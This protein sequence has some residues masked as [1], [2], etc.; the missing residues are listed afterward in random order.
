MKE[1]LLHGKFALRE[2]E[3]EGERGKS[4]VR[5]ERRKV[6]GREEEKGRGRVGQGGE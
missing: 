2:R 1:S 4:G 5:G 3:G 6:R